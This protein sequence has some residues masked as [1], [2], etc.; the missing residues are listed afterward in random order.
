M[1][2]KKTP[3]KA[4]DQSRDAEWSLVGMCFLQWKNERECQYQGVIR[5]VAAPGVL[6]CQYFDA[7]MG[8]PSSATLIKMDDMLGSGGRKP[9]GYTLF[10]DDAHIRDWIDTWYRPAR[11]TKE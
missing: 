4:D 8:N 5:G 3:P 10:K 11:A 1:T 2:A 6:I 9:G 7:I